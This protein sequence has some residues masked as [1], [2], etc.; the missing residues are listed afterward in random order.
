M[1]PDGVIPNCVRIAYTLCVH[2]TVTSVDT[3]AIP[4]EEP[5]RLPHES[6]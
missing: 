3:C 6:R 2:C 4:S 1:Q 5:R